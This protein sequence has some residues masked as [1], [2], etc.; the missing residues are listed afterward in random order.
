ML[1]KNICVHEKK[2]LNQRNVTGSLVSGLDGSVL[3]VR[4]ASDSEFNIEISILNNLMLS[5]TIYLVSPP[6]SLSVYLPQFEV[7][8]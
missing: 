7:S 2:V 1:N 3:C 8:K 4:V 6:F 5:V